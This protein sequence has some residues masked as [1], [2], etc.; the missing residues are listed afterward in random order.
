MQEQI[1]QANAGSIKRYTV[2]EAWKEYSVTLEV[3]HDILTPERAA[4]INEFWS[5]HE[6]RLSD[7]DGD[8]V[9]AVV[10]LAGSSLINVML[11]EGGAGFSETTNGPFG[12]NPG[13]YWTKDLHEQEGWGGTEEGNPFGWC[14]IRCIAADVEV[15]GF[16]TVELKEVAH[17]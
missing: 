2:E 9:R 7:E 17:G 12:G 6:C 3:N 10:R 5:D 13:P 4:M 14:G 8:V 15:P 16:S 11:A 1:T